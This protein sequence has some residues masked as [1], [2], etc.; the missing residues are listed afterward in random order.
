ME[1]TFFTGNDGLQ[2]LFIYQTIFNNMNIK[3]VNNEYNISAWKSKGIYNFEL[4]LLHDLEPTFILPYL[5]H[6]GGKIA[7]R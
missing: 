2:N 6:S 3:Q 7:M 4:R 1:R 5:L